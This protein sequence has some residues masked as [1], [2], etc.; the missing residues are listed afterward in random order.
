MTCPG[1]K[2]RHIIADNLKIFGEKK[3]NIED[4]L[5]EKGQDVRKGTVSAEG[6]IEF[7]EDGTVTVRGE[8]EKDG[9]VKRWVKKEGAEAERE[10][11]MVPGSTFA[12]AK[13]GGKEEK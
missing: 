3:M 9:S 12:S 6:D 2:N 1:C 11:E 10:K 13:T 8:D 4:I 7:W 5:R